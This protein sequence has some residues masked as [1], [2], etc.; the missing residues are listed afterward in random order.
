MNKNLETHEPPLSS[1]GR[2][3]VIILGYTISLL[4]ILHFSLVFDFFKPNK[5]I[6]VLVFSETFSPD[7]IERFEQE[8]GISVNLTYVE[9]DEQIYA[10]FA[11][12]GG[13]GYDVVNISDYI[14][15]TLSQQGL[16]HPID[17]S[18]IKSLPSIDE[19]LMHKSYDQENVFSMP[20]KW[21]MYGL[22]YSKEFF[23]VSPEAMTLDY[24][25][26]DPETL[27]KEGK[28]PSPYKVCM[29]DDGRDAVFI[30]ALYLFGRVTDLGPEEYKAIQALLLQQKNWV[31][32]YTSYSAQYFLFS[33]VTPIALMSS[34]Y[35]IKILDNSDRFAFSVPKEGSTMVIENLA[36]PKTCKR[37]DWAH[38]FIDFM[39]SD[40]IAT[41]NSLD[42]EY[43]S[44]NKK[45]MDSV[46][47]EH[48]DNKHLFP[49][50]KIF[51]KLFIPLLPQ[52]FRKTVEDLWLEVGFS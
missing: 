22:V 44:S 3:A 16:L 1:L 49:D 6:N 4:C 13:E 32:S 38:Q 5:N 28:V 25:F 17:H 48:R 52:D 50:S 7:A 37:V 39:L 23:G 21:Y 2:K 12:N 51:Q 18:K 9:V 36:I 27:Y 11:I 15:Y 45:A 8:T 24:I 43:N 34:N 26:K 31:E 14:V 35:M 46:D 40:E 47:Q 30:A 19:E 33:N 20:H 41:I 29:L 42:Y 10:K